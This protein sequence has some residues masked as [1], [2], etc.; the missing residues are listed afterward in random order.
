MSPGLQ[1]KAFLNVLDSRPL[2]EIVGMWDPGDGGVVFYCY[3]QGLV[4]G[5]SDLGDERIIFNVRNVT[6]GNLCRVD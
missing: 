4:L 3:I 1:H 2:A 6:D 5:F